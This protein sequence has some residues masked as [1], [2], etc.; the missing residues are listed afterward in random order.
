MNM[1][2]FSCDLY[3]ADQLRQLDRI[4]IETFGIPGIELMNRAGCAAF[5]RLRA[6]WPGVRRLAVLCGTGNN[7]GD[8]FIV[9]RRA[10]EAGLQVSLYQVGDES[11]LAGETPGRRPSRP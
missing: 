11:R 7:G 5:E 6:R 2:P 3:R 10:R 8:G 4:A 1:G 9:A